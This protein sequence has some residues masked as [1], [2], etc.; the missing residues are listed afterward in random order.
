MVIMSMP[1]ALQTHITPDDK[2]PS[3]IE[4]LERFAPVNPLQYIAIRFSPSTCA[5][6]V[7]KPRTYAGISSQVDREHLVI[8]VHGYCHDQ[9]DL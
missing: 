1:K 9:L 5:K 6:I 7:Q 2:A 3:M 8:V 4:I